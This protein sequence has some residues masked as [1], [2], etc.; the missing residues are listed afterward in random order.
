MKWA[1]I[2]VAMLPLAFLSLHRLS[3]ADA[4]AGDEEIRSLLRERVALAG[5]DTGIAVA[6][7]DRTG[8]RTICCGTTGGTNSRPVTGATVFEIGSVTKVFT[9][10][11]L[12]DM[13]KRGEVSLN[14]P[15]AKYLPG[16]VTV[17]SRDNR[18]ITL[19]DLATHTSGLPRLPGNL[20]P[21][22]PDNP[23]A[24]YTVE[25]MYR[26]LSSYRLPRAPG[27][28]YEYSNFGMGLLGHVLALRAGTNYEALVLERI[29]R[30]LG[31]TSTRIALSPELKARLAFGHA[32]AGQPVANWDLPTLAG[33]GAL[34]STTDDLAKFLA[35]CLDL[36][37]SDLWP[38]AQLTFQPRNEAGM[39]DMDIGLAWHIS[40]RFGTE[41]IWHNG[42]TGGYHSFIGLEPGRKKGVVVLANSARS[43]DDLGFH[44]LE[45]AYP[46][47]PSGPARA[48]VAIALPP[49]V[50]DHY[51]GRYQLFPGAEFRIRREGTR[52]MAR[53][54]GQPF[55]EIYPESETEFFYKVV[56]AQ[57]SFET[58]ADGAV[59]G[60]V[61]HQNGMDQTAKKIPDTP[62]RP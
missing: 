35:A 14:D 46:L 1:I 29:C 37:R 31:M 53:L 28:Q 34:R 60:L 42:G 57:L 32:A 7:M 24:D 13:V 54:T 15:V 33:A 11:L 40:K 58:N 17:P 20:A 48:R 49:S 56:D 21:R 22:N 43:I 3:A 5:A 38:S 47:A 52:L 41:V 19:L 27:T 36:T 30:P 45:P 44:L 51:A 18:A 23:Y 39:P 25:D 12:A 59:T 26:F 9:A 6:L 61:L 4:A 62:S 8:T 16:S 10:L 2:T 55:F 50:L